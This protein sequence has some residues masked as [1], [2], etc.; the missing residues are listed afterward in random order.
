MTIASVNEL[1]EFCLDNGINIKG[2]DRIPEIKTSPIYFDAGDPDGLYEAEGFLLTYAE[3]ADGRIVPLAKVSERYQLVQHYETVGM[4]LDRL[5]KSDF[6]IQEVKI[7]VNDDG[8]K[9]L[10][11]VI[12]KDIVEIGKNDQLRP[13]I[14]VKNSCDVTQK[15]QI[16]Y[17]CM[18]LVCTNGMVVPDNRMQSYSLARRH[19]KST[20]N[21]NEI[22]GKFT[23]SFQNLALKLETFR[24]WQELPVNKDE[25]E[26]VGKEADFSEKQQEKILAL[27]LKGFDNVTLDELIRT[28]KATAWTSYNAFTQFISE[29]IKSPIRRQEKTEKVTKTFAEILH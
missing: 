26:K 6:P 12:A 11:R 8:G 5:V 13:E 24:S 28:S 25:I 1:R 21:I 14:V 18:R 16:T 3:F 17:G 23:T 27:P 7:S 20:L 19:N 22:V 10:A 4:V 9:S 29:K 2:I 15:F